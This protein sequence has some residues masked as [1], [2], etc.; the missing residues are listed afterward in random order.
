MHLIITF[1]TTLAGIQA[2]QCVN[3]DIKLLAEVTPMMCVLKAQEKIAEAARLYQGW[4]IRRY[5]CIPAGR[6]GLVPGRAGL[7]EASR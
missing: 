4:S 1:C 3:E 7:D 5:A 2:P 6:I